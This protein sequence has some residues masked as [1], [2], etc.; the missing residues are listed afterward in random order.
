MRGQ[1]NGAVRAALADG[2]LHFQHGP[3]DLIIGLDGEA[4]AV[5]AA[6]ARAWDTFAPLLPALVEELAALRRPL[7][8]AYPLLRHP[9]AR[10]MARAAWPHREVLV[11]PMAAVAGAV[12]DA[13]LAAAVDAGGGPPLA[14]AYVNNGGDIALYLAPGQSYAAGVVGNIDQPQLDAGTRISAEMPVRGIASSGWRGRSFSRGIADNVTVLATDAAAA[15]VAATLIAN[16]IDID[17]PGIRRAPARHLDP[18]SDLGDTAVTIAV[19]ELP[20][21]AVQAALLAGVD[22]ARSMQARG[23]IHGAVLMLQERHCTVSG[24]A[25][26]LSGRGAR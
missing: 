15:D 24:L 12:A 13:V 4:A 11:T 6:G 2:R 7:D 23:L 3:I 26:A 19:G 14:R 8:V 5:R 17:H 25:P 22:A 21:A 16:A 1:G 20:E 9:V 18:D 10:A